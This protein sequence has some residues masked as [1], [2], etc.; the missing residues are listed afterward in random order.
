MNSLLLKEVIFSF[1][2]FRVINL[3]PIVSGRGK[4]GEID[5]KSKRSFLENQK[6]GDK[7]FFGEKQIFSNQKISNKFS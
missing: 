4:Q 2:F 7:N 3:S 1:P 6:K 5:S